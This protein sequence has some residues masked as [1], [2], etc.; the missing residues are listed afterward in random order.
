M[1]H[2]Q[3]GVRAERNLRGRGLCIS[4]KP[5]KQGKHFVLNE[6]TVTVDS[7]PL[8]ASVALLAKIGIDDPVV[9]ELRK[10][11]DLGW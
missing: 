9:T 7:Q 3:F 6:L 4:G 1:S 11:L 10:Y 5:A 2:A 8:R